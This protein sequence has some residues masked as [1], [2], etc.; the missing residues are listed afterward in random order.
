M[1]WQNA[2]AWAKL[3]SPEMLSASRTPVRH[4]QMFKEFLRALVGVE[5]AHLQVKHRFAR[6]AEPEVAGR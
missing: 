5:Q 3:E 1:A 6:D 2:V 4:R